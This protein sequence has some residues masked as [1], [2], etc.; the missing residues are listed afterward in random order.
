M[1][2]PLRG[3]AVGASRPLRGSCALCPAGALS[4]CQHGGLL[5][6]QSHPGGLCSADDQPPFPQRSLNCNTTY[7]EEPNVLRTAL[8]ESTASLDSTIRSGPSGRP[9]CPPGGGVAQ[10]SEQMQASSPPS[11]S[12]W[13]SPKPGLTGAPRALRDSCDPWVMV[14]SPP[15]PPSLGT[16]GARS[17]ACPLGQRGVAT[18]S[19]IHPSSPGAPRNPTVRVPL[20]VVS[21]QP[22]RLLPGGCG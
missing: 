5:W 12:C 19:Q 17:S 1:L 21:R 4:G 6:R 13:E 11:H 8:G 3:Q 20:R 7:S 9:C 10:L 15:S 16:K 18:G 2:W 22:A 14:L